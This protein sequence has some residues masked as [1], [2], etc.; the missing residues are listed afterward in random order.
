MESNDLLEAS[1]QPNDT[2]VAVPA[3]DIVTSQILL[4]TLL[5]RIGNCCLVLSVIL[6]LGQIIN[7]SVEWDRSASSVITGFGFS[8]LLFMSWA[9]IVSFYGKGA[10]EVRNY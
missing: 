7:T 5:H 8:I 4:E 10:S 2:E 1:G 9:C 6:C 3:E